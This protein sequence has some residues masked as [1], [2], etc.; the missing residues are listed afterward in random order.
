[1]TLTKDIL[2]PIDE[3]HDRA[4]SLVDQAYYANKKGEITSA[5]Q[6]YREAFQYERAAAMLLINDYT[7]EPSRSILFRSAASILLQIPN[8]TAQDYRE[9]ERMAALG[10]AGNPP[11]KI[12]P[13]L[14]EILL[15]CHA[16]YLQKSRA[17]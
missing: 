4:M 9:A 16:F 10:L 15:E 7:M 17:A 5:E 3:L 11:D 14:W 12:M 8:K 2:A 1:M 6:L 13:E